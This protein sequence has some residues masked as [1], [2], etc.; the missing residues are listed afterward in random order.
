MK[1]RN[2]L[3]AAIA[4]FAIA[5]GSVAAASDNS[6]Y[7]EKIEARLLNFG[8][9]AQRIPLENSVSAAEFSAM[10]IR[11]LSLESTIEIDAE[12]GWAYG[13]IER[14]RSLGLYNS[15]TDLDEYGSL[16]LKNAVLIA[17]AALGYGNVSKLSGERQFGEAIK[18]GLL[19]DVHPLD[20]ESL[21]RRDA[22]GIIYNMLSC[23]L[24]IGT[25]YSKDAVTYSIDKG[26]TLLSDLY[27]LKDRK[28]ME[29]IVEASSIT[30]LFGNDVCDNGEV[31]ISGIKYKSNNSGAENFIGEHVCFYA[32]Y[33]KSSDVGEITYITTH[34]DNKTITIS[35]RDIEYGNLNEV[36]YLE[37]GKKKTIYLDSASYIYNNK[38]VTSYGTVPVDY[39][40]GRFT[41]ISNDK[42]DEYEIVLAYE[43]FSSIIEDR[44]GDWL[45]TFESPSALNGK[46][47]IEIDEE[48]ED[49]FT[50]VYARNGE[51][52]DVSVIQKG[53]PVSFL[54]SSDGKYIAAYV[55]DEPIKGKVDAIDQSER[56]IEINGEAFYCTNDLVLP[57]VGDS[58]LFYRDINGEIFKVKEDY[59]DYVYVY[60]AAAAKNLSKTVEIKVFD[61]KDF[62][63]YP[64]AS[65]AK[66]DGV[67][68]TNPE[69]ALNA[70]ETQTV[71]SINV[72]KSGEIS[73]ID[74]A[75]EYAGKGERI[76]IKN[77]NGF[78]D[79]N[80]K[81]VPAFSCDELTK[82]FFIPT[83][84]EEDDFFN[85]FPLTDDTEYI[86]SAYDMDT[87]TK[88][89]RAAVVLMDCDNPIS[90]GFNAAS[91]IMAVNK[92]TAI[93]DENGD[94][95]YNV[96]GLCNR[97]LVSY[98]A[99]QKQSVF[100]VL[101]QV[102][103]GDVIQFVLN[104]ENEIA[105][106]R[107][108]MDK[109]SLSSFF[110]NDSDYKNIRM[111]SEIKKIDKGIMTN[112]RKYRVNEIYA[113]VDGRD[114]KFTVPY[115]LEGVAGTDNKGF[116]NYFIYDRD[117]KEFRNGSIS[118][119]I[120]SEFGAG[121]ATDV[122]I[123]ANGTTVQFIVE[124]K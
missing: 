55:C 106:V 35:S 74:F 115:S 112:L 57:E 11:S 33:S 97:E 12:K 52:A 30:A 8:I 70:L 121:E 116:K 48:D 62:I 108:V 73:R 90:S 117:K 71:A 98:V 60:K 22:Y 122:F 77:D 104:W 84:G 27:N 32:D 4:A 69:S 61:G 79:Y 58:A 81:E 63:I 17:Y 83:S 23:D 64:L 15:C 21:T 120:T 45:F 75:D 88:N 82:F 28:Y 7:D 91:E 94:Y 20:D 44:T 25:T 113:E 53:D 54:V 110:Y 50:A 29:G 92:V 86:T 89:A 40:K 39:S 67:S 3:L 119:I 9:I 78:S 101:S 65:K 42:D 14:A 41:F 5:I 13:Y 99:A 107:R 100:N 47:G 37:N 105:L 24:C 114:L 49:L 87:G 38:A 59:D 102:E 36:C 34:K 56:Q 6:A 118:T 76:Y 111:Y 66:I 85:T 68:Y 72:K 43:I 96:T 103:S 51:K 109:S 46:T 80:N 26:H 18:L 16:S 2:R 10:V 19:D 31:I 1:I 95:S 124:M 93:K 123:R